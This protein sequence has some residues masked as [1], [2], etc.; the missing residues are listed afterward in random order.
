MTTS[1][2]VK[3]TPFDH[4]RLS[5]WREG[6]TASID[7]AR[8]VAAFFGVDIREALVGARLLTEEEAFGPEYE[9]RSVS[10]P[11]RLQVRDLTNEELAEEVAR[12]LSQKD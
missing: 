9:S 11:R 1:D 8:D 3:G 6:A 12:R 10:K 7:A 4:A 5:R 2:L